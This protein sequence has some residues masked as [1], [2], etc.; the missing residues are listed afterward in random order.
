[1]N[2]YNTLYKNSS[3][4]LFLA[5]LLIAIVFPA[6]GQAAAAL[7]ESGSL[8]SFAGNAVAL[9]IVDGSSGSI[10]SFGVGIATEP[11][12]PCSTFKI[13]NTLIG[14][15]TGLLT[16]PDQEFYRWDGQA[17]AIASWNRDLTLREAFQV[18]CVPA[19]QA[20]ARN[21][22]QDRMQAWLQSIDYGDRDISAGIDC[23]WLPAKSRK[24]ILITPTEQAVLMQ[25]LVSG[26]LPFSQQA[27]SFL[28][29]LMRA[30]TTDRGTLYG[31]TGSGTGQ[32]GGYA[33]GWFVGFV[34][35]KKG[36]HC[37]ACAVKGDAVTG[38]DARAI[39][40]AFLEEQGYL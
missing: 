18:S 23:F 10:R 16:S 8:R 5:A 33:L 3:G 6:R 7:A 29:E 13:W 40:E 22:G 24:T 1:M 38:K 25:K 17:R 9:V 27:F 2:I 4:I 26:A 31:K 37:F 12:P 15:E 36:L 20:L 19:F 30:R 11:L 39:V 34:E 14:H 21:I 35:T 32:H 28:K